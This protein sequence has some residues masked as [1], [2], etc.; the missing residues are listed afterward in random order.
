M[1]VILTLILLDM[2]SLL[3]DITQKVK[4]KMKDSGLL[5]TVGELTGVNKDILDL[6]MEIPVVSVSK[7]LDLNSE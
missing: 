1:T 4:M 5:K 7:L 3:S 2:L 6:D